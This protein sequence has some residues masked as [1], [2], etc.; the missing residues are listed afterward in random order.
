MLFL[1]TYSL[2]SCDVLVS[3]QHDCSILV[4]MCLGFPSRIKWI[5]ATRVEAENMSSLILITDI[6]ISQATI[7]RNRNENN[8]YTGDMLLNVVFWFSWLSGL[9]AQATTA[10]KFAH[11]FQDG[12]AQFLFIKT[13]GSGAEG[14]AQLV[15]HTQT[16]ELAV[17]KVSTNVDTME[18]NSL[19]H[20]NFELQR[21]SP[22]ELPKIARLLNTQSIQSEQVLYIDYCNGGDL[23]TLLNDFRQRNLQ[24]PRA[25]ILHM[26]RDILESLHF[27]YT[28]SPPIYHRDAHIFN[29]FL[30]WKDESSPK[31]GFYLGDFGFATMDPGSDR[32]LRADL[33]TLQGNI[34]YLLDAGE[35]KH[36]GDWKY[37]DILFNVL[38]ELEKATVFEDEAEMVANVASLVGFVSGIPEASP[39]FWQ[40][41]RSR[42]QVQVVP[43]VYD[44]EEE[45]VNSNHVH[46]PW[47]VAT[48]YMDGENR[49]RVH[50]VKPEVYSPSVAEKD[51]PVVII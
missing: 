37:S 28:C 41:M 14:V 27:L 39:E 44:T 15:S 20:I 13:L 47:Y 1:H 17:R 46:G 8:R 51:A 9:L 19:T 32:D 11:L 31:P 24:V 30:S 21:R 29:I 12:D 42:P 10:A 34:G 2:C 50:G 36:P 6:T 48:V 40:S 49:M 43:Q 5:S 7:P 23:G 22:P 16:G 3:A 25:L 38:A 26:I 33:E 45:I 18:L 35:L 4:Q